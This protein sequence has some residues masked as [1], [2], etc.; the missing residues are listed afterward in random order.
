MDIVFGFISGSFILF[1][2]FNVSFY[3]A[4][5]LLALYY[6]S[7]VYLKLGIVMS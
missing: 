4:S 5:F 3:A 6:G 7:V 1:Q 2:W